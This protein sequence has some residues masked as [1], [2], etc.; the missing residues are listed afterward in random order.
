MEKS[1]WKKKYGGEYAYVCLRV[2]GN[3]RDLIK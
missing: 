2:D 3:V 1:T